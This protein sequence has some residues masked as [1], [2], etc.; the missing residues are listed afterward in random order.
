MHTS[1]REMNVTGE[2]EV[3]NKDPFHILINHMKRRGAPQDVY[4]RRQI[5]DVI[6]DEKK[7]RKVVKYLRAMTPLG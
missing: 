5:T 7:R 3:K 1:H 6:S 4:M 2:E